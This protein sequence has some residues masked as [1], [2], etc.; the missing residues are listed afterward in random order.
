MC[1]NQDIISLEWLY[2]ID[3][4]VCVCVYIY[5]FSKVYIYAIYK[6]TSKKSMLQNVTHIRLLIS[7]YISASNIYGYISVYKYCKNTSMK[8]MPQ[9]VT[10]TATYIR[11]YISAR[12]PIGT[13]TYHSPVPAQLEHVYQRALGL[14]AVTSVRPQ[15]PVQCPH[16][17]HSGPAVPH[18]HIT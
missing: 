13:H 17:G 10:Y 1:I 11:V 3:L 18:T 8:S 12:T 16:T 14:M 15:C 6:N 5:I 9:K 2:S 7:E 4:C